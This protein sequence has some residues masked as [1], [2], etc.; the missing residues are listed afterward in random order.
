MDNL[1]K[2]IGIVEHSFKTTNAAG[3][4]IQLRCKFDFRTCTDTDIKSWL[5]GSR[6]ITFQRVIRSL[7]ES[8]IRALDDTTVN[9]ATCGQKIK[10]R[11]E[12]VSAF[13]T[14]FLNAG[15]EPKKARQLAGAAVDNP[16]ILDVKEK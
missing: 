9:A 3:V 4:E 7:N 16:E 6:A 1:G 5:A 12:Q 10:S 8:E 11:E 2:M 13:E 14:A 15:I